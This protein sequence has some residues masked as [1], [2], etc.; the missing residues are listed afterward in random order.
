M[1]VDINAIKHTCNTLR[2][3]TL[4]EFPDL[5]LHFIIYDRDKKSD[6]LSREEEELSSHVAGKEAIKHYRRHK[7][8]DKT[9]FLGL[10]YSN[11]RSFFKLKPTAQFIALF[12]ICTDDHA[13]SESAQHFIYHE[14][15]HALE[16]YRN[17]KAGHAE[18]IRNED[19]LV[20]PEYKELRQLSQN[21]MADA[22]YA[23]LLAL[24]TGKSETGR[25]A[26]RR[27][28]ETLG[29]KIGATPE[30]YPFPIAMETTELVYEELKDMYSGS[31]NNMLSLA[32]QM[33][34]EVG[35]THKEQSLKQWKI[36]TMLAQEMAWI[37]YNHERILSAGSYTSEDP[38]VRTTAY[39]IAEIMETEPEPWGDFKA[40][41]P[42]T[43][44]EMNIRIHNKACDHIYKNVMTHITSIQDTKLFLDE[45]EKRNSALLKGQVL[46]W[47]SPALLA[48]SK[49]FR[50]E[51]ITEAKE[52]AAAS[53][54]SAKDTVPWSILKNLSRDLMIARR[55]GDQ[56][57]SKRIK[58][59]AAQ[60]EDLK[61]V[62]EMF[63]AAS[64]EAAPKQDSIE[65]KQD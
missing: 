48:A 63:D 28:E 4:T 11:V 50:G 51:D 60:N 25:I 19:N 47:C 9:G 46:G 13:D 14:F 33:T 27:A 3:Q 29:N 45:A 39:I 23:V 49:A 6:I 2:R 26:K 44:D 21:M 40:Y 54:Q 56:I 5:T 52:M 35:I 24:Q 58:A 30:L 57:D 37:G 22:F 12:Y 8:S 59:M 10:A 17:Y 7:N 43:D 62:V 31:K 36:F 64:S 53:F 20:T 65:I 16:T 32:I 18:N 55:Q 15:W 41:N 38:Y 61:I 34:R 42:F 1:T